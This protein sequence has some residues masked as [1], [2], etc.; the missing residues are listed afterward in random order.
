MFLIVLWAHTLRH[1]GLV[2]LGVLEAYLLGEILQ[3][4]SKPFTP[5]GEVGSWVPCSWVLPQW[6]WGLWWYC[7]SVSPTNFD[8]T[9]LLHQTCR[10]HSASFW[11]CFRGR[12]SICSL[13]L[14]CPWERV[15]SGA[16]YVAILDGTL[17]SYSNKD[18][19]KE[20]EEWWN[21][22]VGWYNS[23]TSNQLLIICQFFLLHHL[24]YCIILQKGLRE[25]WCHL[26]Y[27]LFVCLFVLSF[28]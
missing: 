28:H 25:V 17:P 27:S 12:C 6:R 2:E 10:C 19:N 11:I 3:V 9:F 1:L 8:M 21:H 22:L 16:S 18:Y 24:K 23:E 13:E 14:V 20:M 4:K 5:Q 7:V 15:S 26:L